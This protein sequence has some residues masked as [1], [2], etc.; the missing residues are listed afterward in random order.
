VVDLFTAN[1][2]PVGAE[3]ILLFTELLKGCIP[4]LLIFMRIGSF[5]VFHYF[6]HV[7]IEYLKILYNENAVDA[8]KVTDRS[9]LKTA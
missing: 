6:H 4:L 5:R 7:F 3:G 9:Q 1:A 8:S 2:T